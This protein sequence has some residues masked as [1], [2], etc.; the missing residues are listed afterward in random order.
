MR[1]LPLMETGHLEFLIRAV[2]LI[3]VEAEPDQQGIESELIFIIST[4]GIEPPPP[5]ITGLRPYSASRA[6]LAVR[7]QRLSLGISR[8]RPWNIT[9]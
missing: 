4:T 9:S 6:A 3:V 2:H 5:I 1:A 7:T 8:P